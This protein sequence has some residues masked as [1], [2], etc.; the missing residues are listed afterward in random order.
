MVR[1][2]LRDSAF[3]GALVHFERVAARLS[4]AQAAAD[5]GVTPSAVS[6]RIATLETM[7]GQRLFERSPRRVSLTREGT[8][9]ANSTREAL[10]ELRR[11]TDAIAGRRVL[12]V[13]VGPYLSTNWLMPRLAT[14]EGAHPGLRIDLLHRAGWPELKNIDLAIVWSDTPHGDVPAEQLFEAECV[15]VAAPG[16]LGDGAIWKQGSPPLHYRDRVV[17]RQWLGETGGPRD[18]AESGEIFD[19][20]NLVLEAAAHRRGIAMGF[21]P[22]ITEQFTSGRLV[23][24][25]PVSLRSNFRYWLVRG[26]ARTEVIEKFVEWLK[27]EAAMT[28]QGGR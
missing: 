8:D 20:P 16:M 6:H 27:T 10:A 4:F 19:D 28:E 7:L 24:V 22:F 1:P 2:D 26:E 14:F 17:W 3:L 21:L 12:R 18:Y 25:H 23:R 15:P 13:T 11:A 5:L 9:L